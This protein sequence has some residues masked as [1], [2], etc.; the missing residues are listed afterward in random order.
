MAL[1]FDTIETNNNNNETDNTIY[2][3]YKQVKG[4]TNSGC[5]DVLIFKNTV[6]LAKYNL[7]YFGG[8]VQVNEAFSSL[9]KKISI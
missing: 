6:K 3:I 7:I 5:N 9:K 4:A 8:D 2:Q 1:I